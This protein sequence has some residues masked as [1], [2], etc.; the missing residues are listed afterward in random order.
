MYGSAA[1]DGA[2]A[3][4][5][6]QKDEEPFLKGLSERSIRHGFVQKVY[7]IL[8]VQLLATTG[9]AAGIMEWIQRENILWT[10]PLL[11]QSLVVLSAVVALA[12][13]CTWM[14]N[15]I[16]M[17]TAPANYILLAVYT[18][19]EAVLIGVVCSAYT[20][21]S[22]LVVL[23]LLIIVVVGLS[24]FACQ[25]S[26]DFTGLGPYLMVALL[27][28]CGFGLFVSLLGWTGILFTPAFS[29]LHI[30]FAAFGA[31]LFSALL[32]FDTQMI[33]GG[34]HHK[35]QIDL[36]DYCMAAIVLYC[37]IVEMFLLLLELCGQRR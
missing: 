3:P 7:G 8:A 17:R 16:L 4:A 10:S 28:F 29:I 6:P 31:L 13:T 19:A 5:M 37:D 1:A 35:Y 20:L 34:A 9:V 27:I 30:V 32:V 2:A 18:L 25:T 11:L 33:V 24:A 36:D 14:C 21:Q 15:P 12:V 26:W 23:A 22:I